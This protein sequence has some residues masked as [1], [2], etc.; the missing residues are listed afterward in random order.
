MK[1]RRLTEPRSQKQSDKSR[2][3]SGSVSKYVRTYAIRYPSVGECLRRGV[4][5][6]SALAREIKKELPSARTPALVAAVRRLAQRTRG[7][8]G[9]DAHLDKVFFRSKLSAQGGMALLI[10]VQGADFAAI[11]QLKQLAARNGETFLF[12]EGL[13]NFTIVASHVLVPE[14]RKALGKTIVASYKD[15]SLISLRLPYGSVHTHGISARLTGLLAGAGIV[16]YQ[17]MTSAGEYFML[18]ET[19]KLS[20]A[21]ALLEYRRRV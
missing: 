7:T 20:A 8:L 9:S 13:V 10:C 14:I 1:T 18:L 19:E 11:T 5:N 4:I 15:L 21:V 6:H 16:I 12:M 3:A 2:S 17:E